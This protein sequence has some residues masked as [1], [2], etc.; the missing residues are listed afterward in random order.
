MSPCSACPLAGI[1]CT[2]SY[3]GICINSIPIYRAIRSTFLQLLF[4]PFSESGTLRDLDLW[5][6]GRHLGELKSLL[7]HC[8]NT[9]V[10][11]V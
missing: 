8:I 9:P 11:E 7:M 6:L 4:H 5:M 2:E 1:P 3:F 10:L